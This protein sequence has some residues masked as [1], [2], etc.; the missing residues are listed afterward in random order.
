MFWRDLWESR[1]M[2]TA[3]YSESLHTVTTQMTIT[4]KK[5]TRITTRPSGIP[6]TEVGIQIQNIKWQEKSIPHVTWLQ[7]CQVFCYLSQNYISE[8]SNSQSFHSHP[9]HNCE[10]CNCITN[11]VTNY[12]SMSTHLFVFRFNPICLSNTPSVMSAHTAKSLIL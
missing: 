8:H 7:N 1:E 10:L 12:L 3:C 9:L 4:V 6:A 5:L 11:P 2:E